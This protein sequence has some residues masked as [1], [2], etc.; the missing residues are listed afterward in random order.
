MR[1]H[2]VFQ[3]EDGITAALL[4]ETVFQGLHDLCRIAVAVRVLVGQL[5]SS[6]GRFAGA[7]GVGEGGSDVAEA[8]ELGEAEDDFVGHGG[9]HFRGKVYS[10]Y[11]AAQGSEPLRG[12]GGSSTPKLAGLRPDG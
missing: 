6:V 10:L 12:A 2:H 7:V 9:R 11:L 8:L 1:R 5:G 4:G 3:P